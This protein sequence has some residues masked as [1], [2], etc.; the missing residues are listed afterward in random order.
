MAAEFKSQG[1]DAAK[2][3]DP[4]IS[5]ENAAQALKMKDLGN[6][7]LKEKKYAEA[8]AM[9]T[10]GIKL[11]PSNHALFS[12]RSA[13]R[14]MAKNVDGAVEDAKKCTEIAPKWS[15]GFGRLGES[16]TLRFCLHAPMMQSILKWL[17]CTIRF[18]AFYAL[19]PRVTW[20]PRRV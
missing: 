11:D 16:Q 10:A 5:T 15:K 3:A 18:V 14:L 8:D 9:Y 12:N 20:F 4:T 13:A 19:W 17:L 6:R 1:G 2:A 7:A